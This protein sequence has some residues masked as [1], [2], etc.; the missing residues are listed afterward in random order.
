MTFYQQA[1]GLHHEVIRHTRGG[2][3]SSIGFGRYGE[4][5]FFLLTLVLRGSS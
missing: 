1:F 5:D 2:D 3:F 4:N